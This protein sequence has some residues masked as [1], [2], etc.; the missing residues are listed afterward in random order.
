MYADTP[1]LDGVFDD[2]EG[3]CLQADISTTADTD[4][5]AFL[6]PE[7]PEEH[8]QYDIICDI[9]F[10]SKYDTEVDYKDVKMSD[11]Y[12]KIMQSLKVKESE[13]CVHVMY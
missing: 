6:Y 11:A 7:R 2:T 10:I 3:E 4:Q 12:N 9:G 13:L 1:N 8:T 5:Y